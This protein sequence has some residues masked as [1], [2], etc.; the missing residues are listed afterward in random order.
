M[1]VREALQSDA[2]AIGKLAAEFASYL[3]KL[4]DTGPLKMS[5]EAFLRDGFGDKPAFTGLVAE[6]DGTVAGYLLYHFGYDADNAARN[7][8]IIDLFVSED[9]RGQGIGR[10]LMQEAARRC[11]EAGGTELFWA[12]FKPNK[13]AAE[14]YKKL[15]ASYVNTLDFM[16][17][18]AERLK[19]IQD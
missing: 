4:G 14:F 15:G 9:S 8:H 19:A 11:R 13:L 7:L 1:T 17:L 18:E 2:P 16:K 10:A 3:R 12:I 5:A 6:K